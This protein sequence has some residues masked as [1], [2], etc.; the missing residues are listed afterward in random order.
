MAAWTT[1]PEDGIAIS[2]RDALQRFARDGSPEAF[3]MLTRRYGA[4]VLATCRR[5]L[6]AD[7]DA[8]EAAQETFLKLARH[9]GR[10]RSNV[11]A[12]LHA[13]AVGTA[14]DLGRR[15]AVRGRAEREAAR[16]ADLT[17]TPEHARLWREIEPIVDR[18][19]T[20]LADADRELIVARFLAGRS[21]ADLAR[22][23][24]VS[25]GTVS[26]RL[27][28][29]LDRLRA[30]LIAGGVSLGGVGA[31]SA[32]F[33]A[34][35][36][37]TGSAAFQSG[38]GKLALTGLTRAG[39]GA[40]T[41]S[42]GVLV[43]ASV[44]ILLVGVVSV[45]GL[46]AG[47]ANAGAVGL[48]S[49]SATSEP[50]PPRPARTIGPFSIVSTFDESFSERGVFISETNL[51]IGHGTTDEGEVKR[52]TL[53]I[54]RTERGERRDDGRD[55]LEARVER[56]TPIDDP[57]SRFGVGQRVSIAVEFDDLGR[58]VLEPLNDG[59]QLGRNEPR[60]FGVRPPKGWIEYG[61]IP[62][63]AGPLGILGPWA[64]AERVQMR[65][66][67]R[68]IRF[69]SEKWP[70]STYRIMDWEQREGF[71]RVL[72]VHANGRD[73]RLIGTRFRLI[74]RRDADGYTIAYLPPGRGSGAWPTSFEYSDASP[75][76][77]V[78]V[79]DGS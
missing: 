26:R 66:T 21:Q 51:S 45:A 19:L 38:V 24:G 29:A 41:K 28:R 55:V 65:I 40:A 30:K 2:D 56:I 25:E 12:W 70:L 49:G 52:A 4:M 44:V 3:E 53:R 20:E 72:A 17:A 67:D 63:D 74:I 76:R 60:W 79:K 73:P 57:Y 32:A 54:L 34:A 42:A 1:H 77:V 14:I 78:R 61:R 62:D 64:E 50:G 46:R 5:R 9:A 27:R 10:V 59:P 18:A 23:L 6:P 58:L 47:H 36:A 39:A 22:E 71:S 68:E 16:S 13:A 48:A 37:G 69:G 31:L 43:G 33:A 35:P 7:A 8:E 75:V 11:A 15:A